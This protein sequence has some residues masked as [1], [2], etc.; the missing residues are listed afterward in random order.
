MCKR[1]SGDDLR[2][3]EPGDNLLVLF[4]RVIRIIPILKA[5]SKEFWEAMFRYTIS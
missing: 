3:L 5:H 2:P 4:R 1:C